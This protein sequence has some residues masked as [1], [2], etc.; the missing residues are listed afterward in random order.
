MVILYVCT[1]ERNHTDR[2]V[3]GALYLQPATVGM[4]FAFGRILYCLILVS[5]VERAVLR[6]GIL[7]T[8]SG[9]EPS[10]IKEI[11][12]CAVRNPPLS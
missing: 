4:N 1:V 7:R 5:D 3:S 9:G 10:S 11:F 8:M 2:G 6:N 12:S